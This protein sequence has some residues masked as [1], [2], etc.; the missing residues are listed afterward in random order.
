MHGKSNIY[1]LTIEEI[2]KKNEERRAK[3]THSLNARSE[4]K[5]NSS[6]MRGKNMKKRQTSIQIS[7]TSSHSANNNDAEKK[8]QGRSNADGLGRN[9]SFN[10]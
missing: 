8:A 9:D 5:S 2:A 6:S 3:S 10:R 4:A 1:K 7:D